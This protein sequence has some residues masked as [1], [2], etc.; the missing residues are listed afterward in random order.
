MEVTMISRGVEISIA[1]GVAE[2]EDDTY[3]D[4]FFRFFLFFSISILNSFY[5]GHGTTVLNLTVLGTMEF[6]PSTG[7]VVQNLRLQ[8]IPPPPS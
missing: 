6:Q 8:S 5:R 7:H 4:R 2:T 3:C 1:G